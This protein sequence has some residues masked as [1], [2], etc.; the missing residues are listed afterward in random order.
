MAGTITDRRR[1]LTGS[2][3]IKTS[4]VCASTGNLTLSGAQTV[5]GIAVTDERVLAK[6]Q[7]D[8]VKNGIY[9]VASAAWT[10]AADWDGSLDVKEGT[11]VLV[12]RGTANSGQIWA[13]STTGDIT[14]DTTSVAFVKI[15]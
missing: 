3:A 8:G 10:R 4:V 13:V 2:A 11:M 12:S 6:N 9:N 14:V 5:D 7:T 1:G 15:V